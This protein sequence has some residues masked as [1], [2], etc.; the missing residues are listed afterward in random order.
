MPIDQT[1][2][3]QRM[4]ALGYIT[5]LIGKWHLGNQDKMLP[6]ERGFQDYFGFLG[7]AHPY[8]PGKGKEILRGTKA[9]DEKEYLTDALGREAVA[10]IDKNANDPFM[11]Y[12]AFNA[13][14][15]PMQATDKYLNRFPNIQDKQR[16]T[17]AAMLSAMDDAIGQVLA[18]LREKGLE[19]NTLIF[20]FSDNGGPTMKGTTINGSNN[21]AAPRARSGR[22]LEGGVRVPFVLSVE[23][24]PTA[25][26]GKAYDHPVIAARRAADRAHRGRKRTQRGMEARWRELAIPGRNE[27]G[28]AHEMLYWRP[29]RSAC[30]TQ[31][32][33]ED[34]PL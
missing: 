15:T 17:Y 4:R 24:A 30:R 27:Q 11:L 22:S 3:A 16:K 10:F 20:F 29:R 23:S 18:K 5:A 26:P 34:G 9:I 21:I 28:R 33:L 13:V 7:G 12:L 32:R 14:H 19:E 31:R 8:F 2:I 6:T 25:R 1:T